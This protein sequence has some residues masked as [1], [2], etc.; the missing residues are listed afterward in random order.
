MRAVEYRRLAQMYAFV[1]E[2]KD[3]RGDEGGLLVGV[4]AR[5][6]RGSEAE[7]GPGGAQQFRELAAVR[8]N[9]DVGDGEDF[10]GGA[11]VGLKPEDAR[12]GVALRE[13]VDA[14]D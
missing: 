1:P 11:V 13:F 2:F 8:G 5:H 6:E 10:G 14:F 7:G 9:R 3:A 12:F 4:A